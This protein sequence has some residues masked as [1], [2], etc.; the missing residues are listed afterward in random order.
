M[1]RTALVRAQALVKP[2]ARNVATSSRLLSKESTE[3][4]EQFDQ[5][6]EKFF[7]QQD[8]DG[9]DIRRGITDLWGHDLVPEPKILAAA[10]QACRRANDLALAVRI[11]EAVKDKCGKREAEIYPW[12]IQELRP[13]LTQLGIST[14]EELGI[15]KPELHTPSVFDL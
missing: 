1:F 11:L 5:R 4:D 13:T 12:V 3:T 15:D 6:Y 2:A 14:P 9:W 8:I 7:S 10:L